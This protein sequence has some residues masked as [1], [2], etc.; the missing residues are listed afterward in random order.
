MQKNLLASH[1]SQGALAAEAA[2]LSDCQPGDQL[3]HL[4]VIPAWWAEM[5]GDD[6]LNNGVSRNSYRQHLESELKKEY[7]SV[8]QRVQHACEQRNI[9]Y[10][11]LLIVGDGERTLCA[12]GADYQK[13]FIGSRRPKNYQGLRD[14]ML[15][16]KVLRAFKDRL[17]IIDYPHA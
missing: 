13:I 7:E 6:W 9:G 4:Y 2:A 15:T 11:A 5:T 8:V 12:L 10:N 1:G 17:K 14:R 3:D 16:K